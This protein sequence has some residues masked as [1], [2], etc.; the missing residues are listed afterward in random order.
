MFAVKENLRSNRCDSQSTTIGL[1]SSY[2]EAEA[3]MPED[4]ST[5]DEDGGFWEYS[6]SIME[7]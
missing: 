7:I 2:E 6:Y 5:S 3:A 1:Y 4:Y